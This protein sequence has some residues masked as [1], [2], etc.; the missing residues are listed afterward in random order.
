[1]PR[2]S[3][4]TRTIK[5]PALLERALKSVL[6]QSF[7]DWQWVVVTPDPDVSVAPLLERYESQIRGRSRVLRFESSAPGM[8]GQ[9]LNHAIANTQSEF[10]TVLD[11]DDTWEPSFLER[12][13]GCLECPPAPSVAGAVCQT[14]CQNESSLEEGLRPLD[15]Y[16]LNPELRSI[17]LAQLAVVNRFCTHAFVYRRSA[18]EKTGLYPEDYPVL[19]DWHFNLRFVLH[20]DIAVI[21][22]VLTTYHLRPEV[23]SGAEANSQH[24]ELDLH[25]FFESHL[26]NDYLRQDLA[27]GRAG[28]G[29]ILATAA[30]SRALS[31]RLHK[32]EGRVKAMSEKVGK[33]DA[34]TREMKSTG[35]R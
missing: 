19:E 8:R 26:I 5:R 20:W 7:D 22:E 35:K 17:T 9:P 34:R 24:A 3:I 6:A 1:M 33:I 12:M 2:I 27:S 18:L 29:H 21:P 11:D 13:T 10:I 14:L 25:K 16:H 30:Q 28:L 32:I 15:H 23:K 31:D 4:I